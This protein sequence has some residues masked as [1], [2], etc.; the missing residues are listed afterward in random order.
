MKIE[1]FEWR[2]GEE[3]FEKFEV[4]ALREVEVELK[5]KKWDFF[6]GSI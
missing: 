2:E 4:V 5:G 3:G 1:D 6:L